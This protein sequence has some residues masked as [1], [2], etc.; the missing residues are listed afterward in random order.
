M[1]LQAIAFLHSYKQLNKAAISLTLNAPQHPV[2]TWTEGLAPF[3]YISM[4]LA[5]RSIGPY[6]IESVISSTAVR[7]PSSLCDD[8]FVENRRM[9]RLSQK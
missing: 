3:K 5:L 4:K 8:D 1:S 7:L 9:D 6:M 2:L